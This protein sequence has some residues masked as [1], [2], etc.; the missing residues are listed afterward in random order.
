MAATHVGYGSAGLAFERLRLGR[1]I[2]LWKSFPFTRVQE[3]PSNGDVVWENFLSFVGTSIAANRGNYW[4]KDTGW[5]SFEA[6]TTGTIQ[7]SATDFPIPGTGAMG[8]GTAGSS[9]GVIKLRNVTTAH[10]STQME[11]GGGANGAAANGIYG[12]GSNA[13]VTVPG[14][15]TLPKLYFECR[16]RF[17]QNAN[18]GLFVG[19]CTPG[20]TSAINTIFSAADVLGPLNAIGFGVTPVAS[21]GFAT[22]ATKIQPFYASAGGAIQ[23]ANQSGFTGSVGGIPSTADYP[24]SV[25]A[26][27][28]AANVAGLLTDF[29]KIGF[30]FDPSDV[31]P[32]RFYQDGVLLATQT[33]SQIVAANWPSNGQLTPTIYTQSTGSNTAS[34]G[35]DVDWVCIGQTMNIE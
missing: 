34:V 29:T 32:L 12:L 17:P 22:S 4:G 25:A 13:S 30:V 11:M 3:D 1:S 21:T 33:L 20:K 24:G 26:L 18:N 9:L 8:I 31:Q 6:T 19:L 14:A 2:N 5:T 16:I 7:P 15:G 23:A 10:N 28:P 27:V 35:I